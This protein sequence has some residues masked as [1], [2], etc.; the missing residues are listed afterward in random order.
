M[1]AAT[2]IE[3]AGLAYN[4]CFTLWTANTL[5]TKLTAFAAAC[6]P[7]FI[8]DRPGDQPCGNWL[9]LIAALAK[10]MIAVD[11][12]FTDLNAA[13]QYVFRFCWLTTSLNTLTIVSNAQAAAVLA[14]YNAQLD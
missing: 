9:V 3:A 14:A 11:V 5:K 10:D 12:P 8:E 2:L 4:N 6:A 13:A 1:A 7:V